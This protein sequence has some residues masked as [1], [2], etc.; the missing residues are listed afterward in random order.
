MVCAGSLAYA[1]E[2]MDLALATAE[3]GF[4]EESARTVRRK[5]KDLMRMS[6]HKVAKML[7]TKGGASLLVCPAPIAAHLPG[8]TGGLGKRAL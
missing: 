8:S 3:A 7:M 5:T 2:V 1:N 6:A 4:A